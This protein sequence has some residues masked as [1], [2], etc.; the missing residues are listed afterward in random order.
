LGRSSLGSLSRTHLAWA[1]DASVKSGPPREWAPIGINQFVINPM[2]SI[3]GRDI[4]ITGVVEP[5][6]LVN[7][8][9]VISVNDDFETM[10]VNL[11]AHRI[12]LREGGKVF[13]SSSL[14]LQG[15]YH[16]LKQLCKLQQMRFPKY[17]VATG[18][19]Q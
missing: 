2:D 9:D 16:E 4:E 13:A 15:F 17:F 1:T 12:Q 6:L 18:P 3:G 14:L 8:A 19:S 10:I 5:V 7:P 11:A